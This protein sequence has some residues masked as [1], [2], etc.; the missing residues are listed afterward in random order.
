MAREIFKNLPDKTTPLSASKLNGIFNG[1]EA[2][3]SIVVEDIESK[4]LFDI[5]KN[6][7]NAWVDTKGEIATDE[8]KV[9]ALY[10]YISVKP[11][12]TYTLSANQSIFGLRAFG[13]DKNKTYIERHT[14]GNNVSTI[15]FTTSENVEYL[16]ILI[17]YDNSKKIN[18]D[19]I[20]SL[21]PQ[22]EIGTKTNYTPYKK[23]GYNSQETMGEIVVDDIS[24]KNKFNINNVK[25]IS[26]LTRNGGVLTATAYANNTGQTLKELCPELEVG[27]TYTLSF[28][29]TARGG[30]A[31]HQ[32]DIIYLNSSTLKWQ[33]GTSRTITENDLSS[34]VYFYGSYGDYV[35]ETTTIT[36]IQI[37]KGN[38]VTPYTPYKK[39]VYNENESMGKII[40][41]DISSKN[42]FNKY[43]SLNDSV[44]WTSGAT[45]LQSDGTIKAT[46][47]IANG[48]GKGQMIE[49]KPYTKYA[50]SFKV[51]QM[52]IEGTYHIRII[53]GNK[54]TLHTYSNT[55]LG[56]KTFTF[57][58]QS[59]NSVWVSICGINNA[60]S[61]NTFKYVIYDEIQLE[62]GNKAT[63]YTPYKN[64]EGR[65]DII[66][67]QEM[68]TN[69]YIDGKRVYVKRFNC[70]L[71]PNASSIIIA[72]GL[73]NIDW[74]DFRGVASDG[75][76]WPYKM[77][78][79]KT[80]DYCILLGIDNYAI[81]ITTYVSGFVTYTGYVDLYYTKRDTSTQSASTM[82]LT[83]GITE[84]ETNL[85]EDEISTTSLEENEVV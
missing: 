44:G 48:N 28:K 65:T 85:M 66:T 53:D 34:S 84:G 79:S 71:L 55:T 27:K 60:S 77:V 61:V 2:M 19:I 73:T 51:L 7:I 45:T 76:G 32:T 56:Y 5:D 16:R 49:V 6:Y 64:F 20:M 39:F 14:S 38:K 74:V 8:A 10:D 33:I 67:G 35:G 18:K 17:N 37:E 31:N 22:L 41:D 50:F 40:V 4:N 59:S 12:T 13:Y 82:S 52:E 30:D 63:P 47:N 62:L 42:L 23:Y 83:R 25:G 78:T 68:P 58:T 57:E 69:E 21:E 15:T 1:E 46:A 24:C 3:G 81:K 36:D 70:G 54:T 43:G 75:G 72:T 26:T 9:N 29:T 11:L 80:S